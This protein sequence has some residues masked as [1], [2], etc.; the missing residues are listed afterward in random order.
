[1]PVDV[2]RSG[3]AVLGYIVSGSEPPSTTGFVTPR[4]AELQVGHIVLPCGH[5]I[6]RHKHRSTAREAIG[7]AELVMVQRGRCEVDLYDS[8]CRMVATRELRQGDLLV[9]LG[10][11]HGFRMLEDTVLLEVKQ[12]PYQGLSGKE[13]F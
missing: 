7:T 8:E 3:E 6:P 9:M 5:E 2:V 10:C 1:M 11:G 13:L 4:D 12:G